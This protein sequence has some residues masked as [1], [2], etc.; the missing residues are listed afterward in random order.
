MSPWIMWDFRFSRQRAWS[1]DFSGMYCRVVT[2]KWTDVSEVRTASVIALMMDAV[3]ASETS[4]N[5]NVTTQCYIPEDSKLNLES[6]SWKCAR[7]SKIYHSHKI[8]QVHDYIFLTFHD[9][10]TISLPLIVF[11]RTPFWEEWNIAKLNKIHK[12]MPEN[13]LFM[14]VPWIT[15]RKRFPPRIC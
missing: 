2:L 10:K 12:F 1:L 14:S 5:F 9:F 15:Q 6:V 13:L 11:L 7:W 3:S 4:V 8:L